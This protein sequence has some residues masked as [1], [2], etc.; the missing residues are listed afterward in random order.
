MDKQFILEFVEKKLRDPTYSDIGKT[1]LNCVELVLN[2]EDYVEI[3]NGTIIPLWERIN[4]KS[5][6]VHKFI[7]EA[8]EWIR[9]GMRYLPSCK[10]MVRYLEEGEEGC[11]INRYCSS[12]KFREE[13]EFY[14]TYEVK[15]G[16]KYTI[17]ERLERL[18]ITINES[19]QYLK[20]Q[21]QKLT[22]VNF[23]WD[24]ILRIEDN[25]IEEFFLERLD[26]T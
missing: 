1:L 24:L 20:K 18:W 13:C 15:E 4:E 17:H 7:E 16:Y 14:Y 2:G 21:D 10:M 23:V 12:C 5:L 19:I 26:I 6:K 3:I 22:M 9:E 8:R 11:P 25:N